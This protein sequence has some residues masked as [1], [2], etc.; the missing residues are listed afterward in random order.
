MNNIDLL[1]TNY[2]RSNRTIDTV[3]LT[4]L[5][6]KDRQTVVYVYNY[7]GYHFRIFKDIFEISN[8]LLNEEYKIIKDF[9]KEDDCYSYLSKFNFIT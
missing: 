8:F 9:D 6:S 2:L 7:E 5:K 1:Q 4:D 3:L